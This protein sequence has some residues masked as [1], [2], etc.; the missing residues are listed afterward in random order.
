MT[1]EEQYIRTD[2]IDLVKVGAQQQQAQLPPLTV[3]E[4]RSHYSYSNGTTTRWK[5][6]RRR[7][8]SNSI[9]ETCGVIRLG[10]VQHHHRSGA[11]VEGTCP[12]TTWHIMET[13]QD[14]LHDM[15]ETLSPPNVLQRLMHCLDRPPTTE[16]P[17]G[18]GETV[19]CP[20]T[21]SVKY[22]SYL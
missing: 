8:A 6:A 17:P 3:Y 12:W 7:A 16:K 18:G 11:A 15:G 20:N 9:K 1:G 2:G 22:S 21:F 5:G 4:R 10:E 19:I 14:R 13:A